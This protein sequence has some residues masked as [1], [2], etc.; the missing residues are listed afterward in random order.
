MK[1]FSYIALFLVLYL[2]L[3][4]SPALSARRYKEVEIKGLIIHSEQYLL[5]HLNLT[6]LKSGRP[7]FKETAKKI[8]RFYRTGGYVLAKTFLVEET[9]YKLTLFVD[10]GR[11]GAV[12]F[13]NLNTIQTLRMR[14]E[15]ELK[16]KIYNKYVIKKELKR[17]EE[18]YGYKNIISK[19]KRAK[20][21]EEAFIQLDDEFDIPVLGRTSLPFFEKHGYRYNLYLYFKKGSKGKKEEKALELD[22]K[23]SY[24][25]GFIPEVEYTHPSLFQKKDELITGAS[26]GIRYGYYGLDLDLERAPEWTFMEARSDYHFA[27]AFKK[28]F[29][30]L[31]RLSVENSRSSRNDLG[32]DRYKFLVMNATLAPGITLL[33]KLKIY[34]GIGGERVNILDPET[35]PDADNPVTIEKEKDNWAF[36]ES[37]ITYNL[38][39]LPGSGSDKKI[40][41]TYRYYLN[42]HDFHILKANGDADYGIGGLS[43]YTVAVD[44]L[45]TWQDSPFYHQDSVSDSAFRGFMGDDYYSDTTARNSHEIKTSLYR[46]FIYGG[47]FTDLV[48]FEG[49]GYDVSGNQYGFVSGISGHLIFLDQ[50]EFNI[51]WGRDY[52][53][54]EKKS[55]YNVYMKLHKKW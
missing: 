6:K 25:K 31:I 55:R 19:T 17:L 28:Y 45:K 39:W 16:H 52:I 46:A 15:F 22:I 7:H 42:S 13:K 37:R 11:L 35:D 49:S 43:I 14:Y 30:P 40:E 32:L 24:S 3:P 29:T 8:D 4:Q 21:Y 41:I 26:M 1:V 38:T 10:E 9:K 23:T 27:P 47:V 20:K 53:Y 33:K 12:V 5:I 51:Y 2:S 44:F 48:W 50:F 34:A 54:P 18:K 36:F